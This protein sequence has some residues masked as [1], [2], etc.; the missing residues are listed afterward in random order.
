LNRQEGLTIIMVTHN[1]DLV[2]DGDRVVRLVG[3]RVEDATSE[4]VAPLAV[5]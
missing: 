5:P 4:A 1:L 3:G 2:A